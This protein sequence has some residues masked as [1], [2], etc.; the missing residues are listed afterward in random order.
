MKKFL[1][2]TLAVVAVVIIGVL[3]YLK[4]RKLSDFE[5]AIKARLQLL[6]ANATDSLYRLDFDTL[7]ADVLT[8]TIT[9]AG[10]RLQADSMVMQRMKAKGDLP[11]N[12]FNIA[13]DT[14]RVTGI[15]IRDF[16][17][18]KKINLDSL[19]I[20]HPNVAIYHTPHTQAPVKRNVNITSLYDKM[21][22]QL[23]RLSIT[24]LRVSNM[25]LEHHNAGRGKKLSLDR[26]NI[27]FDDILMDS[28]TARDTTRFLFAK[29]AVA[30]LG[31]LQVPTADSLYYIS[32]DS[33]SLN[34][35]QN[36]AAIQRIKVRPR[37]NR[38]AF[39]NRLS[40]QKDMYDITFNNIDLQNIGWNS[41]L[42]G[43]S[44]VMD[45]INIGSGKVDIF[46]DRSLPAPPSK[47]GHYPQQLLMKDSLPINI[48]CIKLHGI[49]VWYT[50]FNPRSGHTGKVVFDNVYATA[51]NVTNNKS[52]ID[53]SNFITVN[54]RAMFMGT[55]K[56]R[57]IFKFNL[58]A[59]KRG[60]FTVSAS[61]GSMDATKLNAI[62]RPLGRFGIQKGNI[63]ALT[64][65]VRG[66]NYQATGSVTFLYNN[67]KIELVKNN[68]DSTSFKKRGLLSFIANTFVIKSA[69]PGNNSEARTEQCSHDRDVT[70]S[71]FNLVWKTVEDGIKKTA[72]YKK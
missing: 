17:S 54:A 10:V 11:A 15:D 36:T 27:D 53:A 52:I 56:A 38:Q 8:S 30:S 42:T 4:T 59:A 32:L 20:N 29:N 65:F 22:R 35:V 47:L 9:V 19:Y 12:I 55:A 57:A 6:V 16:L 58:A 64:A 50:E 44:V 28:T 51:T 41:L 24:K 33:L 31:T 69:N 49:D 2:I 39:V 62:T 40:H 71:F 66:N 25:H 37:Y 72:G 63:E 68:D 14:L 70:K 26:V 61:L 60:L 13:V 7:D 67:L 46:T 5:P 34:A 3:V 21:A 45:T 1:L 43:D 23:N 48:R 18:N